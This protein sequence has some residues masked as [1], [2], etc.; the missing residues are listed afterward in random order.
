[1]DNAQLQTIWQQRQ[2]RHDI[3]HLS[4]PLAVMMK[5]KLAPRVRQLSKLS[6]IWDEV[7]PAEINEHTALE[8]MHGGVLTVLVDSASH[9][10]KLNALL[11]AGLQKEIQRRF[12][13][14]LRKIKLIPGQFYSVD[15]SGNPRYEF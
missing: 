6:E 13:N 3:S 8:G 2:F 11:S 14:A 10:F 12:S 9:R 15:V 7:I 1:M 4:H 5:H